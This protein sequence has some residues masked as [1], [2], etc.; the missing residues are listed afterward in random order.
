MSPDELAA[1]NIGEIRWWTISEI[2]QHSGPDF[3]SPTDLA[4]YVELILRQGT[5]DTPFEISNITD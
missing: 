4:T 5:P 1:E 3:L 2:Q